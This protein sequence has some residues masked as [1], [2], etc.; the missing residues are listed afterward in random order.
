MFFCH[1]SLSVARIETA[2]PLCLLKC[3]P[4]SRSVLSPQ[5]WSLRKDIH[6]QGKGVSACDIAV[7]L[8]QCRQQ[9]SIKQ[10]PIFIFTVPL[11]RWKGGFSEAQCNVPVVA[12]ACKRG[13]VCDFIMT[14]GPAVFA[15]FHILSVTLNV[16]M[17]PESFL[18]HVPALPD[19]FCN[20]PFQGKGG[21][22]DS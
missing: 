16:L 2:G 4:V 6:K 19:S 22:P 15:P 10:I 5:H 1:L 20:S 12:E 3:R 13:G 7:C 9:I 8:L 14:I 11:E 18:A 17:I 21:Y